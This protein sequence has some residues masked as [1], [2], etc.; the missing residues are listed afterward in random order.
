MAERAKEF[1]AHQRHVGACAPNVAFRIGEN[2]KCTEI[3]HL[4]ELVQIVG[5]PRLAKHGQYLRQL[6]F[7]L[8]RA[9][10]PR[11]C[12]FLLET[13]TVEDAG[14]D[15]D[16]VKNLVGDAAWWYGEQFLLYGVDRVKEKG[17]KKERVFFFARLSPDRSDP[18]P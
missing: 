1:T 7:I 18:A 6:L 9:A 10:R 2:G 12:T 5:D 8:D 14:R 15:S 13:L 17:E 11:P 3:C 16:D 4:G